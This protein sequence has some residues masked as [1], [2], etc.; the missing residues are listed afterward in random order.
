[1]PTSTSEREARRTHDVSWSWYPVH[2]GSSL[3]HVEIF[4][5]RVDRI[6]AIL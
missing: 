1:M 6:C 4:A 2:K 3:Y 5:R